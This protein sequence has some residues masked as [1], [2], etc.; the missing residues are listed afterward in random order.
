MKH[1]KKQVAAPAFA[2][3]TVLFTSGSQLISALPSSDAKKSGK[4]NALA[5]RKLKQTNSPKHKT[6]TDDLHRSPSTSNLNENKIALQSWKGLGIIDIHAHCG[7]FRGYDLSSENLLSNIKRFGIELALVSNIDGAN[8]PGVTACLSEEES[9]RQC[10][11]LV[12]ENFPKLRGILWCQPGHG[13]PPALERFLNLKEDKKS[14][15]VALKFHPEMNQFPA[16]SKLLDP[17]MNICRKY[18][19][20]AV[21]HCGT[22]GSLSSARRIYEL[23]KRFPEEPVILYHLG[24]GSNHRYVIETVKESMS[25]GNAK[26][27]VETSQCSPQTAI[28]AIRELGADRVLFGTDATYF[29]AKHYEEYVGLVNSCRSK[30]NRSEFTA[31][32]RENA[33]KLF[34]L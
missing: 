22:E 20:P 23:A 21:F 34:K 4:K 26:L 32:F 8:M 11:E 12:R 14:V 17:Y 28:D 18:K 33:R 13:N 9:N 19:I 15:F 30:L 7:T 3:A 31:V 25:R 29:G 16:D 10:L 27:Y 6:K 5:S 2:L 24:F 1:H